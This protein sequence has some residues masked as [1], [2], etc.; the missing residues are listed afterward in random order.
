MPP[1]GLR[2][3]LPLGGLFLP[4]LLLLFVLLLLRLP[5]VGAPQVVVGLRGIAGPFA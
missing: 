3:R 5:A 2:R 1:S 4:A